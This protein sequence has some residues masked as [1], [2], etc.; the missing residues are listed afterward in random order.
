MH[1]D[2]PR[3]PWAFGEEAAQI[4]QRY[5]ALR[6]QWFPYLYSLAHEASATGMPVI[7]AMPLAFPDDANAHGWDLQYML[8]PWLLVAPIYDEGDR[9]EV[10]L[11]A[12][13]WIDY[14]TGARYEG[15]R[16][17][18][19]DAPLDTLPLFVRAGAILPGMEPA[20]RIPQGRIEPLII[21]VYPGPESGYALR[22]DEEITQFRQRRQDGR[23]VLEM[24]APT[25][26][27]VIVRFEGVPSVSSVRVEADGGSSWQ[28]LDG[29]RIEVTLDGAHRARIELRNDGSA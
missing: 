4:V 22:E 9:R 14:W 26:R 25:A 8:G 19:V 6:Y 3:E 21:T 29:G 24:E 11:P 15:P 7:R 23:T 18:T 2:S 10:Y 27:R 16:V 20:R 12:A 17:V 5:V 1:G 28:P 13:E